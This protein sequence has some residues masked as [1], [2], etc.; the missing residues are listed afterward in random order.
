MQF[1]KNILI[2]ED[3]HVNS[4]ILEDRLLELGYEN[5]Y[6]AAT[7]KEALASFSD[8]LDLIFIDINLPDTNGIELT[9]IFRN[10]Y[11]KKEIPIICYSTDFLRCEKE[12]INAG[13]ND[14]LPKPFTLEDLKGIMECWDP[15]FKPIA[16]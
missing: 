5:N 1:Q 12:S 11:N 6:I 16:S 4:K 10:F 2:I 3:S 15:R 8:D 14:F 7:G 13:V 9:K